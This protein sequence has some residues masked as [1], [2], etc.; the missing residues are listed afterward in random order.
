MSY[1]KLKSGEI[2]RIFSDNVSEETLSVLPIDADVEVD[3]CETI[4]YSD[5][6]TRAETLC[7]LKGENND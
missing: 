7:L 5:I 6:E 1:C 3:V 2:F 4:P